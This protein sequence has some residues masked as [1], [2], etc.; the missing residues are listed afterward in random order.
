MIANPTIAFEAC[1]SI[2][3]V[4]R[5]GPYVRQFYVYQDDRRFRNVTLHHQFWEMVQAAMCQMSYLE[6]LYVHDLA[7]HNTFILN[8]A[9]LTFQLG[10][11]Q[12]RLNWDE[13]VVAFLAHQRSIDHLTVMHG[14]INFE[15]PLAPGILPKLKQFVGSMT[16]AVQLTACPLTHLQVHVDESQSVPLLSFLPRLAATA[17]TLR[18]LSVLNVPDSSSHDALRLIA[19]VCPNLQYIGVLPFPSRHVSSY[20]SSSC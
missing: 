14:P 7:G 6:K 15:H 8:P 1:R 3:G 5:L 13:N 2:A 4:E 11:A 17:A 19:T 20:L 10:D 16:I 12:L 18:S 9:F